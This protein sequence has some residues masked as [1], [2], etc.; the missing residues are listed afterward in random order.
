MSLYRLG[1][2]DDAIVEFDKALKIDSNLVNA[3]IGKSFSLFLL[4]KKIEAKQVVNKAI[5]IEPDNQLAHQLKEA[6]EK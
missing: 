2:Y 5:E 1:R 4:D 6:F 3:L